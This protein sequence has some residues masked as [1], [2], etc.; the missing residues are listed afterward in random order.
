MLELC[1]AELGFFDITIMK[2]CS[3]WSANLVL[4]KQK[5][6]VGLNSVFEIG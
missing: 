1:S 5:A 2:F 3:D 6:P 4:N